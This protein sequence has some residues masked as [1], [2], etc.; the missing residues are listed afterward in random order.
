MYWVKGGSV[1]E[2]NESMRLF[3]LDEMVSKVTN[4]NAHINKN[5]LD[6]PVNGL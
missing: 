6:S 3:I 4:T 1:N 5:V 2:A